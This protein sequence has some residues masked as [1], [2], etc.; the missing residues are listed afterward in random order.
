MFTLSFMD[1][2]LSIKTTSA[3]FIAS[4]GLSKDLILLLFFLKLLVLI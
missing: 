3:F 1:I 4:L 2:T